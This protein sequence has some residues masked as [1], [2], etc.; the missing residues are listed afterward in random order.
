MNANSSASASFTLED[1]LDM[2]AIAAG[3]PELLTPSTPLDVPVRWAHVIGIPHPGNMLYGGELVLSTLGG[4]D[5]NHPDPAG[6]LHE[7]L[8]DLD[9]VGA[10]ALMV[11]VFSNRRHLISAIREVATEREKFQAGK[12][13]IFL[14]RR[15]VRFV[16]ITE[17]VQRDLMVNDI[18]IH[19]ETLRL[20]DPL[21][22]AT[23]NLLEDLSSSSG[24]SD[25]E[26]IE[27]AAALGLPST[28]GLPEAGTGA[29]FLTAMVFRVDAAKHVTNQHPQVLSAL[30]RAAS[31]SLRLPALIGNHTGTELAVILPQNAPERFCAAVRD[32]AARRRSYEIVPSY[33]VGVGTVNGRDRVLWRDIPAAIESAAAV[34]EAGARL[35]V[36]RG[37]AGA[38]Y[39]PAESVR[40]KGFWRV[41]DLGLAGLLVQLLPP[42]AAPGRADWYLDHHLA[43]FR[44]EDGPEMRDLVEAYVAVGENKTEL[45]RYLNISR[46]TLYSRIQ[47]CEAAIG[48]PL[49]G[50]RLTILSSVLLLDRLGG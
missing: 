18:E 15:E 13:P 30:I 35:S 33:T 48:G 11:E 12:L 5:E 41:A 39:A 46:P 49:M 3:E 24:L 6:A 42:T 7:F 40:E 8:N 2:S 26:T 45:A 10:A 21:G 19:S 37:S 32:E 50:E 44:G 20:R 9:Y 16:R 43:L 14:F 29:G 1:V 27:R 22:R 25:D 36:R 47:R 38:R 28:A 17:S 34:A 23:T 4:I 31:H